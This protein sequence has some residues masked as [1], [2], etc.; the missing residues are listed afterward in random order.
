MIE[1]NLL[2]SLE[3]AQWYHYMFLS[4]DC[5]EH[6]DW[7]TDGTFPVQAYVCD[8]TITPIFAATFAVADDAGMAG[9]IR[10]VRFWGLSLICFLA[11]TLAQQAVVSNTVHK[12]DASTALAAETASFGAV[13]MVLESREGAGWGPNQEKASKVFIPLSKI[14]L[15]NCLQL[16]LQAAYFSIMYG[17]L[18]KT[19]RMKIMLSVVLGLSVSVGKSLMA[20][21]ENVGPLKFGCRDPA[22]ALC[23]DAFC[24]SVIIVIMFGLAP[25]LS[26]LVSTLV[27]AK[28]I[29]TY[30]CTSHLWNLATGCLVIGS[31]T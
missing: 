5:L 4:V 14:L 9:F 15:E 12:R 3:D 1:L 10:I 18:S 26:L 2:R 13:A 21:Y 29:F 28:I 27:L 30:Q 19:A 25:A 20:L 16:Y 22:H 31:T 8:A 17:A 7:F 24:E 6:L 23:M 11:A